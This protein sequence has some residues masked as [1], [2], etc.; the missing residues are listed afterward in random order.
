VQPKHSSLSVELQRAGYCATEGPT[1]AIEP[2]CSDRWDLA[3]QRPI[4]KGT[5]AIDQAG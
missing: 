4:D 2:V 5:V 1:I 3:G